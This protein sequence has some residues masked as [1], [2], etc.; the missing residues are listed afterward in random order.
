[1][2]FLKKWITHH[3]MYYKHLQHQHG[4]HVACSTCKVLKFT[5]HLPFTNTENSVLLRD[6]DPFRLLWEISLSRL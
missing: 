5:P 6:D 4:A 2:C 3:V 1:M